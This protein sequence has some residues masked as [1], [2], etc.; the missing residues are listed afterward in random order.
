MTLLNAFTDNLVAFAEI[1]GNRLLTLD[2]QVIQRCTALQGHS[3]ALEITDLEITL[4]CHPGNW[5]I[6][7][8]RKPP[9][10]PVDATISGRLLALFALAVE[11]DKISTSIRQRVSIH[12]D[13]NIAQQIQKII[14]GLD[15]DWEEVLSQY[16]G[17]I[18]AVQ[19][20][21]KARQA[22][23]Y[24]KQ[25]LQALMQT[26]SEYLRE[27]ARL[28]PTLPEFERFQQQIT[29]VRQDADRCEARMYQLQKR[30]G[31]K[32]QP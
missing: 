18:L 16:S 24:F 11:D 4:Y 1:G 31:E 13:A 8:S 29:A 30:I 14:S 2:E 9:A 32:K 21:R 27:E 25:N 10:K 3:I 7:L 28:T 26:S 17:D 5:G 22:G 6:R 12:G 15:I 19:I 20:H 23:E